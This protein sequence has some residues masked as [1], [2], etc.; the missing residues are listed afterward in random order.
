MFHLEGLRNV[1]ISA[2]FQRYLLNILIGRNHDYRNVF[3]QSSALY[4][5]TNLTPVHARHPNVEEEQIGQVLLHILGHC[6][7]NSSLDVIARLFEH[8]G[9]GV[10]DSWIIIGNEYLLIQ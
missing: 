1:V 2:A 3:S 5:F 7:I 8:Y 4:P 9:E 6:S 10:Q